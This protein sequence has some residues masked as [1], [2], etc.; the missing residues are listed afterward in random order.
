MRVALTSEPGRAPAPVDLAALSALVTRARGLAGRT[1]GELAQLLAAPLPAAPE[2]AKGSVGRLLERALDV[3][4]GNVE[5]SDFPHC[6]LKTLPVDVQG[7]PRES[8]F[9]CHVQLTSLV[10]VSWEAS[11]VRAKLLRVLF[12]PIESGAQLAHTQRRIGLPFLWEMSAAQEAAL[13]DDYVLLADRVAQGRLESV[14]ARW[15][16]A[17]QLRPKAANSGIRVRAHDA[18]GTPLRVLPRAFYLRA[19]FT[20]GL[21]SEALA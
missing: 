2:R 10:E 1:L 6:E 19:S 17:L 3:P 5:P 15:G 14:D 11:R 9:V 20:R 8:T 7:R 13:R 4:A 16:Q 12:V 18:D 21:L